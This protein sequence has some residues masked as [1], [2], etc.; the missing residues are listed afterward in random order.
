MKIFVKRP[1]SLIL[2]IMLGGFSL[3]IDA[4]LPL[5]ITLLSFTLLLFLLTFVKSLI[6]ESKRIISRLCLIAFAISL[7]L[8][9][10]WS[11]SFY[12]TKY[13]NKECKITAMVTDVSE[14]DD[15][16]YVILKTQTIDGGQEAYKMSAY[17]YNSTEDV[18]LGDIIECT[19]TVISTGAANDDNKTSYNKDGISAI[20][21]GVRDFKVTY[22]KNLWLRS[23]LIS[24]RNN[25]TDTLIERTNL[26][27]GGFMTALL[28]GVRDYLDA[29]T[30]LSFRRIGI[31]HIL[32]LSGMHLSIITLAL[33]RLLCA[34]RISKKPR[35]IIAIIFTLLYMSLAGFTPSITRSGIMLI[36]YYSL[37]LLARSRDSFTSLCISVEVIVIVKP[38]AIFDISL[39]LSALATLGIVTAPV[40][41]KYGENIGKFKRI[42]IGFA[43]SLTASLFAVGA[44]VMICALTFEQISILSIFATIVFSPIITIFMYLSVFLLILGGI[45]PFGGIM[46]YF[47]DAI[48]ELSEIFARPSFILCSTNNLVTKALIAL[49]TVMLIGF[50]VLSIKKKGR[51]ALVL[52]LLFIS[53]Y[54]AGS[55]STLTNLYKDDT[56]Y[57]KSDTQDCV[58]IKNSGSVYLIATEE[59]S[60]SYSSYL[61]SVLVNQEL[62]LLDELVLTSYSEGLENNIQSVINYIKTTL[63]RIPYPKNER[64]DIEARRL[65]HL[66]SLYGTSM[67][68]YNEGDVLALGSHS[69]R[70]LYHTPYSD[71]AV[72]CAF[73][74]SENDKKTTYFTQGAASHLNYSARAL[75]SE[76]DVL[77]LGVP[78][79]ENT[80]NLKF[81]SVSSIICGKDNLSESA[82]NYYQSHDTKTKYIENEHTFEKGRE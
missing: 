43:N 16:T 66:L 1:L 26:S 40:F 61:S 3:F 69:Y 78:G 73:M 49:F 44:T 59:V 14:N 45:I 38:Y 39:W 56:V 47:S 62:T 35:I 65:A 79:T 37:F 41:N 11:N 60:R 48:K 18:R 80:F 36:T 57:M 58:L 28:I 34:L 67:S 72:E 33:E 7:I 5:K 23:I 8:G 21:D 71:S 2:C 31:S 68:F 13:H 25:I 10:I 22:H 29:E 74:L 12:P 70:L 75:A 53:I 63:I 81:P 9:I 20:L 27:T 6:V 77:I 51:A 42:I 4:S 52:F 19:A 54:L 76:S 82:K 50:L 55:I 30:A 15:Y 17:I 64:E 24:A 46:I 32:A